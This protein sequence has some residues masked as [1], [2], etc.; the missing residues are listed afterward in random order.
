[1]WNSIANKLKLAKSLSFVEWLYILL[2]WLF[3]LWYFLYLKWGSFDFLISSASADLQN[4]RFTPFAR[5]LH[6]LVELASRLHLL[7]MTCL[8]R[9]LTL[10]RLLALRG[11]SSLLRI[12]VARVS[13]GVQAHAW[14]EVAGVP[15]GEADDVA[16]KFSL[17][18]HV[19]SHSVYEFTP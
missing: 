9:S 8:P 17:L 11:I 4:A 7:P 14:V 10:Q 3:L 15:M 19:P 13:A 6:R 2:A 5:R 16:E 1:L 12:G 18:E